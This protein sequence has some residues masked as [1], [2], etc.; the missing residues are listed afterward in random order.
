MWKKN[1]E[2]AL[3]NAYMELKDHK[4]KWDVISAEVTKQTGKPFNRERCRNK[5][6]SCKERFERQKKMD[7]RSGS[8]GCT[9][10]EQLERAFSDDMDLNVDPLNSAPN[11]PGNWNY[12][13]YY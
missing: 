5:L 9:V 11:K 7:A 6:K 1:D 3:L 12:C 13:T 4:R 10:E 2:K 8:G